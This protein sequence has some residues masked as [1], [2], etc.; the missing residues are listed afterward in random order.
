MNYINLD[1][2][3]AGDT[4]VVGMSGGVDS[5]FAQKQGLQSN[6]SNNVHLGRKIAGSKV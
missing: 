1:M 2:P 6:R 4:V 5:T 3:K